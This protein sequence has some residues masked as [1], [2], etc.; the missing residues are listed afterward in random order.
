M[1]FLPNPTWEHVCK[2]L[3]LP[4]TKRST[5]VIII[6]CPVHR[7]KTPSMH[8]WPKSHR[9]RCH[10]CHFEGSMEKFLKIFIDTDEA[11]SDAQ[12][13]LRIRLAQHQDERQLEIALPQT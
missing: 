3:K 13:L 12:L 6:L 8:M 10:G 7:E 5:G 2:M 1:D 11:L 4:Y 9:F